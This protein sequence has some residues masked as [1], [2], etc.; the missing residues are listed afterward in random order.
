MSEVSPCCSGLARDPRLPRRGTRAGTCQG[1]AHACCRCGGIALFKQ[2]LEFCLPTLLAPGN[3]PALAKALP[4]RFVLM[5]SGRRTCALIRETSI[6]GGTS[7]MLARQNSSLIDDLVTDGNHSATITLA[8]AR[9]VRSTGGAMLRHVLHI[10][11]VRLHRRRRLA[12]GACWRGCKP[13]HSGVQ[14][15]NFQIV[16]EEAIPLLRHA[17]RSRHLPSTLAPS[18]RADAV[19]RSS[20]CTRQRRPTSSTSQ[21]T[22]NVAHQ[23]AVLARR[24]EH[25]DRPVLSY[26]HDRHPPGDYRLRHRCLVRLFLHSRDVPLQQGRR[27][28]PIPTIIS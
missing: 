2:F 3:M 19:G 12:Y 16:A 17:A 14:A 6:S 11:G 15:G 27:C 4:C 7:R 1:G 26:A 21:L 28:L 5:T 20:I 8:Y 18:P 24:R 10:S 9:A 22:H 23:P 13:A 25:A